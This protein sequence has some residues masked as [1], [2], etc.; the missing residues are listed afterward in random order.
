MLKSFISFF[1]IFSLFSFSKLPHPGITEGESQKPKK[2]HEKEE[3]KTHT[4][5]SQELEFA[6]QPVPMATP[7]VKRRF[8]TELATSKYWR[9]IA[10][11]LTAKADKYFPVVRPILKKYGIPDDFKYV[12]LM[13]SGFT[14][15]VSISGAAGPWQLMP[16]IA[17][18][19]GLTMNSQVDERLNL[20]LST[21]AACKYLYHLHHQLHDWTLAAAAFN[22]GLDGIKNAVEKQKQGSYYKLKLN[23]QAQHYVYRILAAKEVVEHPARYGHLAKSA[24]FHYSIPTFKVKITNSITNLTVFAKKHGISLHT[25]RAYNPW[26]KANRFDNPDR[27]VCYLD[28]P[29][30]TELDMTRVRTI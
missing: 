25:L 22:K 4:I 23:W 6:G 14:N 24:H 5:V 27:K 18:H 16:E 15:K 30:L 17:K 9:F 21:E 19:Y 8:N 13:E 7:A 20:T 2:L 28:I 11:N 12:P 26:L 10:T 1:G 29:I 3:N